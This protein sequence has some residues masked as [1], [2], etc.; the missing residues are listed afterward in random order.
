MIKQILLSV[1]LIALIPFALSA[2]ERRT[3]NGKV[4]SIGENGGLH[5]EP[6]ITVTIQ[7]TSQPDVT[8]SLG[9]FRIFLPDIFK[10]GEKVTLMVDKPGWRIQYP[11]DGEARIPADLKKELVE[12]RLLPKGSK[13]FWS[14]DRIEKLVKDL[15]GKS[16]QQVTP[17]GKPEDIDF[18]R[19]IKEWAVQ[20]G[21]NAKEARNE[22]DKWISEV[23]KKEIDLYK[24]GLAAFAK[25]NFKKAGKLFG[26]SA[27]IKVK[28]LEEIRQKK[29]IIEEKERSLTEEVVRDYMLEGDAHYSN[30]QF[31]N[32]LDAYQK[33]A[34]YISKKQSPQL[35]ASTFIYIG[36]AYGQKGIRTKGG[37]IQEH[38]HAAVNAY[39]KSLE[40]YTRE[41][42]PQDW[43]MTQNNLGNA[44]RNQGTRTGGEEGARLLAEA[45]TAYR[46][47]LK[48][49]TME[50]LPPQWAQTQNNL[51]GV[52]LHLQE[53][54]GTAE[55]YAN[56]LKVY[57]DYK[58]AYLIS[59][60]IYQDMLFKFPEA[61][62]LNKDWLELHPEDVSAL[63]DFTEKHFTTGRFEECDKR[64]KLLLEKT[65]I[66]SAHRIVLKTIEIA[67][68]LAMD[69]SG[70]VPAKTD[71]LIEIITGQT[72]EFKVSLSF[73]GIKYFISK[74]ERLAPF[75]D[76]LLQIFST[77][78]EQ[79]RSTV[80][81]ALQG[82][83]EG[84]KTIENRGPD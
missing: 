4:V 7:E 83:Q 42:L 3:L 23:E 68:L 45:V 75:S 21:F 72:E 80:I 20:Y 9:V 43:A 8:N 84:L 57:P 39:K 58:K 62:N 11:L 13:L 24:L 54:Q 22:I 6:D 12:V 31:G 55:S 61:F 56:V 52:Y 35:W 66:D 5:L 33:A 76:W 41:Q 82:L 53:W 71:S 18:N 74:N 40:V 48:V 44:L 73:E 2:E 59:S 15:S 50:S 14:H 36:N 25:K 63:V 34:N 77:M 26:E 51:A 29:T 37:A 28:R 19:F 79:N 64:I 60:L 17:G 10:S 78:K 30:Y 46:S 47:A 67:N 81:T 65:D 32:A 38:L 49:R 69:G 27:E 1:L 70:H 16:K